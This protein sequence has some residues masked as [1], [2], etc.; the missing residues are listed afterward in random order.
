LP[1]LPNRSPRTRRPARKAPGFT[2]I[3]TLVVLVI[4]VGLVVLMSLLFRSVGHAALALRGGN[5]E[6]AVQ[7]RLREQ[8]ANG[9]TLPGQAWLSGDRRELTFLTWKGRMAGLDGKPVVAQYRFDPTERA[10]TY[11]ELPLPAWWDGTKFP[12]LSQLA[13]DLNAAAPVKLMGGVDELDL[14]FVPPDAV[15]LD[16]R[17]WQ[18]SW[19][20]TPAPKLVVLKFNRTRDIALW[21]DPRSQEAY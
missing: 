5:P 19:Q 17:N 8:L 9:F 7:A 6:W 11:R 4:S 12:S 3:E 21:F 20:Q 14:A 10:L 18:P 16:A 1:V 15:D 2:L 13:A